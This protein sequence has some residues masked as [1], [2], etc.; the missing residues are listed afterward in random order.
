MLDSL[1]F[2]HGL[3]AAVVRDF[4]DKEILMVAFMNQEAVM[5]TLTS[6]IMHYWSRE[7]EE[8]WQKGE[9]SGNRQKVRKVRV[10]CDC[11]ALLFDVDPEGP[12]CHKGYRSCFYRKVEDGSF[13]EIM[14]QEFDPEKVY[15]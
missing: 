4:E 15:D 6:G 2:E 1:N 8:I 3:I 11:D 10:D 12:A 14:E 5:K 7:R 9:E 13:S